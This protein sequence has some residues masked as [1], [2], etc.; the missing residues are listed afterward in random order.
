MGP[1][2][3]SFLPGLG[4]HLTG[5]VTSQAHLVSAA[6]SVE[7]LG[8]QSDLTGAFST[9]TQADQRSPPLTWSGCEEDD[10]GIEQFFLHVKPLNAPSVLLNYSPSDCTTSTSAEILAPPS[11][12]NFPA[13]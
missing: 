3:L 6:S 12:L 8:L 4:V 1:F 11:Q 9:S 5:R 2:L 10:A 13:A 7:M